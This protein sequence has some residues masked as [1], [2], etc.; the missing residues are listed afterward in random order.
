[1][2]KFLCVLLLLLMTVKSLAQNPFVK[3]IENRNDYEIKELINGNKFYFGTSN[4]S[5]YRGSS[6]FSPYKKYSN[7]K[8]NF[9]QKR[10][11]NYS[12]TYFI[13]L[14]KNSNTIWQIEQKHTG[15]GSTGNFNYK[16][17][18]LGN[19]IINAENY[20]DKK[21]Q[22]TNFT[23]YYDD[24]YI[25][26]KGFD[27]D[28][29]IEFFSLLTDYQGVNK[30]LPTTKY[31]LANDFDYVSYIKEHV[32]TKINKWQQKGEFEKIS[33]YSIRVTENE[34]KKNN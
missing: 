24:K 22:F 15:G 31:F 1:M 16:I 9:F 6:F 23:F 17:D 8:L 30:P 11:I 13:S 19:L 7:F 2:K 18:G 33:D 27:N 32:Q 5:I 3:K 21:Y 20:Q 10:S 25:Y 4:D 14:D 29:Y 12:S 26:L 28:K 34:I